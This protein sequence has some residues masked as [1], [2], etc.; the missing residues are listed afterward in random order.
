[1]YGMCAYLTGSRW[2]MKR[3][4]LRQ[5]HWRRN[6]FSTR[7]LECFNKTRIW[8]LRMREKKMLV[9]F[10]FLREG[11]WAIG[12]YMNCERWWKTKKK[13]ERQKE[14]DEKGVEGC[15]RDMTTKWEAEKE[16]EFYYCCECV[17]QAAIKCSWHSSLPAL[18]QYMANGEGK[19]SWDSSTFMFHQSILYY[20]SWKYE[21]KCSV[22]TNNMRIW[23]QYLNSKE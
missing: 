3:M 5:Q 13:E 18:L 19:L 22:R 23:G 4:W 17:C 1:M 21:E 14:T 12:V 6:R 11:C 20:I 9:L 16:S 8:H 15:Q 7:N 10:L 2:M